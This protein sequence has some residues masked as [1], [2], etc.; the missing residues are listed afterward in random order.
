MKLVDNIK[1]QFKDKPTL[2]KVISW[3]FQLVLFVVIF[4]V[5]SWWQQKDMLPSDESSLAPSFT[6]PSI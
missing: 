6:L 2:R 5:A 3:L 1:N 4:K